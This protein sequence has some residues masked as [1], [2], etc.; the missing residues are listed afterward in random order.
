MISVVA[1]Y[2]SGNSVSNQDDANNQRSCH[3]EKTGPSSSVTGLS[4]STV[5]D[6]SASGMCLSAAASGL[7]VTTSNANKRS[8]YK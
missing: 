6:Q 4:A 2:G 1:G 8:V 7:D 5:V 3:D